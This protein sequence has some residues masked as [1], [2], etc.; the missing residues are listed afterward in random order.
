MAELV[1]DRFVDFALY[2]VLD[3][4]SLCALPDFAEHSKETFDMVLDNARKL[5]RD[6]M[7]PAYRPMDQEP[8]RFV[9]GKVLVHAKMH[10]LMKPMVELDLTKATRKP[11]SGG[12]MLP[13]MVATLAMTYTAAA[14]L[15]AGSYFTLTSGASHLIESFG[16]QALKETYGSK[17]NTCE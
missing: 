11:E 1:S 12:M 15:S 6:V 10:A 14:N 16:D 13:N 9:D 5:A 8:P 17:M 7:L 2:E 4:L 3:A